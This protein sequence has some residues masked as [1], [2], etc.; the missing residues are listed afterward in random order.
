[1]NGKSVW[2]NFSIAD[3]FT[4]SELE[5]IAN[6]VVQKPLE[7]IFLGPDPRWNSN[8]AT[9]VEH[10]MFKGRGSLHVVKVLWS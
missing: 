7:R 6:I 4:V 1:M 9:V 3:S 10:G 5:E 2:V 8:Q